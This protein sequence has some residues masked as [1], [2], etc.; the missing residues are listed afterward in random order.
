M[1]NQVIKLLVKSSDLDAPNTFGSTPLH[2]AVFQGKSE[3]FFIPLY[4]S[5]SSFISAGKSAFGARSEH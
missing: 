2:D 3:V 5:F 1:L 4:K